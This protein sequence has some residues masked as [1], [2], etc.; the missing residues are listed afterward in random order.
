MPDNNAEINIRV[1]YDPTGVN[2]AKQ[3]L[4][5]LAAAQQ[6]ANKPAASGAQTAAPTPESLPA[7]TGRD[8]EIQKSELLKKAMQLETL[9]RRELR[10]EI[11]R[12]SSALK[13]AAAAGNTE[14]YSKLKL[15]VE[16]AR[17]AMERLNVAA[18]MSN[19]ALA[20]QALTGMNMAN[21]IGSLAEKAHAG[22]LKVGDLTNGVIGLTM[23]MK[24]G[25]G[26]IGLVMMAVQGLQLAWDSYQ[27]SQ[28]AAVREQDRQARVAR[29]YA[30]SQRAWRAKI[31]ERDAADRKVR[32]AAM[33]QQLQQEAEAQEEALNND[34]KSHDQIRKM[35]EIEDQRKIA[36]IRTRLDTQLKI[37]AEEERAGEITSKQAADKSRAAEDAA[38][39][40]I[41]AA[42][43]ASLQRQKSEHEVNMQSAKDAADALKQQL[44]AQLTPY[45]AL[46]NSDLP[47]PEEYQ[48]LISRVEAGLGTAEDERKDDELDRKTKLIAEQM[49]KAGIYIG[50]SASEVINWLGELKQ[51]RSETQKLIDSY[52]QQATDSQR[53]LELDDQELAAKRDQL[54]VTKA[55][56]AA[57]R[58]TEDAAR[59]RESI[60]KSLGDLDQRYKVSRSYAQQS[61][62]TEAARIEAD[63]QALEERRQELLRMKRTPKL[64]K[65]VYEQ[66]KAAL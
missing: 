4:E 26:P 8:Q 30:E 24:A 41:D 39:A 49:A 35:D 5:D 10:S 57:N 6:E 25:L 36:N 37:I 46:L 59:L 32:V 28:K 56:T 3:D 19:A 63:R 7:A 27:E 60:A 2:K 21:S 43:I 13:S 44:D 1:N 31:D 66:I 17:Q 42:E 40:E 62:G 38:Q 48:A 12:L 20:G 33:K 64:P 16:R 11:L 22:T 29:E 34:R 54:E 23:A 18:N 58:E 45:E 52:E 55:A 50:S 53:A 51:I 47:T 9:T 14:Q 65:D 61:T 15:E